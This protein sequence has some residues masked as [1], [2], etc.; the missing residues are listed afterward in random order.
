MI[1]AKRKPLWIF[2]G[3]LEICVIEGGPVGEW[4]IT[5][6]CI[7]RFKIFLSFKYGEQPLLI[8]R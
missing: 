1:F 7:S 5:G 8:V 2:V 4:G 3:R 6:S